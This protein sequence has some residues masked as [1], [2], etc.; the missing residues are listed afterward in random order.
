MFDYVRTLCTLCICMNAS[1]C[2]GISPRKF[3]RFLAIERA[4]KHLRLVCVLWCMRST[5]IKESGE[6][7]TLIIK[8]T[9]QR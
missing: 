9:N 8:S 5:V 3:K 6:G 4:A 7:A 2:V 1:S